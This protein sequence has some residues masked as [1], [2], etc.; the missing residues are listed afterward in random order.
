MRER[1]GERDRERERNKERE[2][3]KWFYTSSRL[4]PS[5]GC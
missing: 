4:G 5:V 2:T 3:E 1:K